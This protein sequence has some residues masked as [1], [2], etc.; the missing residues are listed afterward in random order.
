MNILRKIWNHRSVLRYIHRTI[1]FN[2]R[3]LPLRQAIKLPIWLYRPYIKSC[4]GCI[5]LTGGGIKTGMIRLGFN[6]VS[7]Y[8]RNGIMIE[9]RGS[10]VFQ[11]RCSIGNDSYISVGN[12]SQIVFGGDFTA[13]ASFRIASYDGITFGNKVSIGWNCMFIDSDF[14]RL[15]RC[16]GKNV[17]AY[18]K[19]Q[20]GNNVWFGNNCIVMKNTI[21]P[22]YI[23][24]AAGTMLTQPMAVPERSVVGNSRNVETLQT[25][26]WRNFDDDNIYYN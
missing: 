23:T 13:T 10:I 7:I 25:G 15:T 19:I 18:G 8:P 2:F 11:G 3:H 14:H 26:I 16:D 12:H 4:E 6:M 9:N 24:V 22:D 5:T 1:C 21:I 17:K 20:V